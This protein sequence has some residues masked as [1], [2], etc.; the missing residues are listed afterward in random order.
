MN[1]QLLTPTSTKSFHLQPQPSPLLP[2]YGRLA[3]S[4]K[5]YISVTFN[6]PSLKAK[7]NMRNLLGFLRWMV[8]LGWFLLTMSADVVVV[9]GFSS[10]TTTTLTP[11]LSSRS[12]SR[13][14]SSEN[15]SNN[16]AK[17]YIQQYYPKFFQILDKN[18]AVW[19]AIG[20]SENG[21]GASFTKR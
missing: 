18:A 17:D 2:L 16:Q 6:I 13:L 20:A 11:P 15:S 10:P 3:S 9:H 5:A 7:R 4:S 14:Y 12:S 19:K 21:G 8:A 1:R